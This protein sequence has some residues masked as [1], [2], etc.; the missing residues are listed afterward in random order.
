MLEQA[1][2]FHSLEQTLQ[3][4]RAG[5]GGARDGG[6][7]QRLVQVAGDPFAG[8]L[9]A[10][11]VMAPRVGAA[12]IAAAAGV[13]HGGHRSRQRSRRRGLPGTGRAAPARASSVR[14]HPAPARP[15]ADRVSAA[16][17]PAAAAPGCRNARP[18]S[19]RQRRCTTGG[20]PGGRQRG[21]RAPPT[22]GAVQAE[23]GTQFPMQDV[24]TDQGVA[25]LHARI[26]DLQ[27]DAGV[28]EQVG[29]PTVAPV[30]I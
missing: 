17:A 24:A 18:H 2:A 1:L 4:A 30:C 3:R 7:G 13:Q 8:A 26:V 5:T 16:R 21:R 25:G 12:G 19:P 28:I 20:L 22:I 6:H 11:P 15:V 27:V 29:P 9:Q 23:A 10:D 14:T